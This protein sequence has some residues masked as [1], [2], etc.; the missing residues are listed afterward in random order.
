MCR[1]SSVFSIYL[2]FPKEVRSKVISRECGRRG[3]ARHS[4]REKSNCCSGELISERTRVTG[5]YICL[6]HF[7]YIELLYITKSTTILI[8][9]NIERFPSEV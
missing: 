2:C 3:N 5:E 7:L 1:F 4:R 9:L 8:L 6:K